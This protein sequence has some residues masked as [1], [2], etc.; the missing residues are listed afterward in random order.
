MKEN[1]LLA[2]TQKEGGAWLVVAELLKLLAANP[3]W[4]IHVAGHSAGSIFMAPLVQLWCGKG[5]ITSG[6]AK[7]LTG[8]GGKITSLTLWAPACTMDLFHEA[9]LPSIQNKS[10]KRFSLFTLKDAADQDDHCANIYHKSLL[11]LVSNALEEKAGLFLADGEPLL[12]L[13]RFVIE[14]RDVF[15]V[16][17]ESE[18]KKKNPPMVPLF[19][20]PAAQ[21]VRSPNGLPEGE[22]ANA[23]HARHHG[24]FDDD[25][26][27]VLSTLA[28]I[29]GSGVG[30]AEVEFAPSASSLRDRRRT[31]V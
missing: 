4:E 6:P 12:G 10:V 11:Y 24:D 28:R 23:S 21:W 8:L 7:G 29:T 15:R 26:A 25:K 19:G 17:T 1:A 14:Q 31:L 27:T 30:Q 9:Y 3:A 22:S 16:P 20:V 2:T 13:E 5:T 18:I